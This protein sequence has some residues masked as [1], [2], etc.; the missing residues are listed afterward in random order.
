[1]LLSMR[2]EA[3][4]YFLE[5]A[6]SKSI[7]KISRRYSIPQQSLSSMIASL[8]SELGSQLFIR[9]RLGFV[10]T[11]SGKLFYQYCSSFFMEYA[12]LQRKLNPQW[13]TDLKKIVVSA[14]NNIAQTLLPNWISL[15][16]KYQ[17]EIETEIKVQSMLSTVED[18]VQDKAQIGFIL[19]FEKGN[20]VYPEI[21]R[22][23]EFHPIFFS[24]PYFWMNQKNP[25]AQYK[26]IHMKM[27]KDYTIIKDQNGDQELFAFIFSEFFGIQAH[28]FKAANAHIM[29]QLV[30]DDIAVCPDL[31]VQK[32]EL[33]LGYLFAQQD[34]IVAVPLSTQDNY[35]IVTGY[36]VRSDFERDNSFSS[37]LKYLQ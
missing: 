9:S 2:L 20:V 14:Q 17:P 36:V 34:G 13:V 23:L 29:A 37:I 27:L 19:R 30:K 24:R 11:E 35:R 25:L 5:V 7:S 31:K 10:P 16:L 4:R 32:G 22:Q 15:L 6:D 33:G 26:T 8:E 12:V 18:V 21:P 3:M 28:F 1:M